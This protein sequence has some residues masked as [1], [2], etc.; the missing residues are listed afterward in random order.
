MRGDTQ[1]GVEVRGRYLD[2]QKEVGL[3][4]S[5]RVRS[6]PLLSSPGRGKGWKVFGDQTYF[7]TLAGYP[8]RSVSTFSYVYTCTPVDLCKGRHRVTT[9]VLPSSGPRSLDPTGMR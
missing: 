8:C 6:L 9:R 4:P 3:D 7:P 2:P 5:G 1:V